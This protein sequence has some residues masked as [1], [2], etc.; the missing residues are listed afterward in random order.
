MARKLYSYQRWSSA[1]QKEGT[2]QQRQSNA[3]KKYAE[4]HGYDLVEIRDDGV[5]AFKSVN[6]KRGALSAFIRAVEDGYIEANSLLY[7]ESLDRISR[8]KVLKA[9]GLF[10][11]LLELRIAI[12]TGV[13]N[14][15]YTAESI[16]ENSMDLIET[17]L[18]FVRGHAESVIK[19][20]RVN[21][22]AET[23]IK[24]FQDGH[25][26]TIKSVGS[27]PWWIDSSTKPHEAVRKHPALWP[28]AQFAINLFLEGHSVFKVTQL[29]NEKYHHLYKGKAWSYAN[30]RKL[31]INPAVYGMRELSVNGQS[32]KLSGYYPPLITEGQYLRLEQIR[33]TTKYLGK[34]G[35]QTN[36]INLLAGMKLFRCGH[37]GGT[38]MAMR[39]GDTIRYLCEKGRGYAHDCKTWS[40]PGI[41]VEHTLMLVT[42]IAYMDIQRKG[43]VS[44]ED[45]TQQ[46][47]NTE[48]LIADIGTRISRATSLVLAGLGN[49]DEV[50][51]QI[52]DLEQQRKDLISELEVLQRRQILSKDKTFESLMMDFFTYAQYGV[53]QDPIHE[54]RNKLRD[55]VRSSISDVRAW[56]ENRRLYISFQIKGY[57]EYFNFSAGKTPY[58]WGCHF[59]SIPFID[60]SKAFATSSIL[61]EK[62]MKEVKAKFE[63]YELASMNMLKHAQDL[64]ETVNYPELDSKLFW[65]RK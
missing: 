5:S 63:A 23:L 6:A 31:R 27:H 14:K 37:C 52:K 34:V 54:Y 51:T 8:D 33:E 30:I 45:Y 39:H 28:A 50:V 12:V 35:E 1:V 19:Q 29:L 18:E 21:G 22:N 2:T 49:V 3:A 20:I 60:N 13:N 9:L 26:T 65:P 7:V 38:M 53:L 17:I 11:D 10:N 62:K 47:T 59:G 15:V 64:L 42:T 40:L 55:I 57:D 58:E 56:K 46:I 25:P 48:N 24:R 16:N 61:T 32:Y 44:S 41:L 43:K 36:N 4:E